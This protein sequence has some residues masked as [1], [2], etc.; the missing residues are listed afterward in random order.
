MREVTFER[1]LPA[2]PARL[3]PRL[4]QALARQGY[5][6]TARSTH[7]FHFLGRSTSGPHR[8]SVRADG[9]AV[10]FTFAPGGVGIGLPDEA[11]LSVQVDAALLALGEPPAPASLQAKPPPAAPSARRCRICASP[12]NAGET[13]CPLCGM[14]NE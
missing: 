14:Q 8:L 9:Q 5:S 13:S 1:P 11:S 6:A 3:L 7:E 4:E 2:D 10:R 12:L